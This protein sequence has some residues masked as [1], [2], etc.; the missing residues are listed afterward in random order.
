M[1][2]WNGFRGAAKR[3][4]DLDLPRIGARIGVG[5]DEIHAIID[6]ESSGGGFDKAGRPKILFEPHVFYRNLSGDKRTRAVREGLAYPKWRRGAP[7]YSDPWG[8]LVKAMAIDETAALKAASWGLGQVLGE[9]FG[10]AG[11]GTPQAMVLDFMADEDNHLEAMIRF[12]IARDLDDELRRHDWTGFAR[13]YNGS[14]Q[15]PYYAG[16]LAI[17]YARWRKIKDTTYDPAADPDVAPV[18]AA[19]AAA[20]PAAEPLADPPAPPSISPATS[21]PTQPSSEGFFMRVFR[22]IARRFGFPT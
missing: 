9:N 16:K 17:A 6:V 10:L 22:A 19:A 21:A 20:E 3:I 5:E 15:V 14:G 1:T 4:E 2:N 12:I 18:I 11:Y 8:Y 7:A 13:G